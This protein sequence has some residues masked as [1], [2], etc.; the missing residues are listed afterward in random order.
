MAETEQHP[1]QDR[2]PLQLITGALDRF[3][4]R[5]TPTPEDLVW[6]QYMARERNRG[7][8]IALI[9]DSQM[10][11]V[12]Q[13]RAIEI[14][15]APDAARLPFAVNVSDHNPGTPW[16]E[17]VTEAQASFIAGRIPEYMHESES[18]GYNYTILKL[19][20]KLPPEQAEGLFQS[21]RVDDPDSM[22]RL[23]YSL[24]TNKTIDE[25]WKQRAADLVHVSIDREQR[26][27]I[28][29][30]A[31]AA[32]SFMGKYTQLIDMLARAEA[33]LPFSRSFYQ[34][35]IAFLLNTEPEKPIVEG[36]STGR[37]LSL[38]DDEELKYRFVR[39]QVL[40]ERSGLHHPFSVHSNEQAVT[41]RVILEQFPEDEELKTNLKGQLQEWQIRS[42]Q[43]RRE[44]EESERIEQDIMAKMRIPTLPS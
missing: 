6:S 42:E 23:Y 24:Y 30:P 9:G 17:D 26:G 19:L 44:A 33:D 38:L 4:G 22:Y 37:V 20:G 21:F 5:N 14:L 40:G 43:M 15:L 25:P 2:G 13:Q 11:P 39:R 1:G 35:E 18:A 28:P 36:Y 8:L 29:L 16:L 3:R 32:E 41:A 34:N 31:F 27:E 7:E 10:Q 12:F